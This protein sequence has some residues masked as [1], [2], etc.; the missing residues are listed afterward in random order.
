MYSILSYDIGRP[1]SVFRCIACVQKLQPVDNTSER[2]C[3][4]EARVLWNA[5]HHR[6]SSHASV[7]MVNLNSTFDREKRKHKFVL[8]QSDC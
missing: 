6:H 2:E 1:Y 8:G 4:P 7:P 5:S 3:A